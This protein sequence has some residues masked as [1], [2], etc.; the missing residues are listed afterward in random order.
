MHRFFVDPE[1]LAGDRVLFSGDVL[2][3]IAKVLRMRPGDELELLD[4]AG[5]ICQCRVLA[6]GRHQGEALVLARR[7]ATEHP[8]PVQLL[9]ALPKGDK[10]DL[11]LQKG[12]ELGITRFVPVLTGRTVPQSEFSREEN[13]LLRWR[14]IVREAAR[15]CRR[16][17][18]PEVASP[19]ALTSALAAVGDGL[20]L[21]LWEEESRPLAGLLEAPRPA[22]ATILVGPEGG[23]AQT[24]VALAA[25]AGFV[26]VRFGPRILRSET[27]GFAVAAILQYVY[28]DLG[29]GGPGEESRAMNAGGEPL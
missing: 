6:L 11:V 28:G 16:P 13:R 27:A 26:P 29:E 7:R 12:T 19:V 21:L 15:Q 9:Q 2:H 8:F 17:V 23:F 5:E 24:E 1:Q 18:I 10:F 22:A 4:G 25:A 14:K 20:R 3:H